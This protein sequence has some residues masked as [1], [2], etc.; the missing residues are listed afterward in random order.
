MGEPRLRILYSG[1]KIPHVEQNVASSCMQVH[2]IVE[3]TRIVSRNIPVGLA[4]VRSVDMVV[5]G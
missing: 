2:C 5:M 4:T 1:P 3:I